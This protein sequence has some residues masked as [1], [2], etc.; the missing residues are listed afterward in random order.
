MRNILLFVL[1]ISSQCVLAQIESQPISKFN[2]FDSA[3]E[4]LL[5]VRTPQEYKEGSIHGAININ[6]LSNDFDE[7]VTKLDRT[8]KI[9]VFCKK[10]G[11]SLKSQARLVELGFNNVVDL[12]GGYDAYSSKD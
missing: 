11:R 5:D 1:I 3:K 4:I 8:K 12:Q 10:G 9:Y 2:G 6:W 7:K